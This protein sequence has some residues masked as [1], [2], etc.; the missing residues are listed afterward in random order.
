[1][2]VLRHQ[3]ILHRGVIYVIITVI[4]VM[5]PDILLSFKKKNNILFLYFILFLTFIIAIFFY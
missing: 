5:R 2:L 4:S 3:Q 1:M